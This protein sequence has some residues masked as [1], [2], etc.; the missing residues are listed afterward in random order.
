MG[1]FAP[2]PH[3]MEICIPHHPFEKRGVKC[4]FLHFTPRFLLRQEGT[5][6]NGHD[7][8]TLTKCPY[9]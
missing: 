1:G 3:L 4:D 7:V 8:L 5:L 6:Y 2:R 9:K